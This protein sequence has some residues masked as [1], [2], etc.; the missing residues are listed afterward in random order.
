MASQ[1]RYFDVDPARF[2]GLFGAKSHH[3]MPS[4]AAVEFEYTRTDII[5]EPKA[6]HEQ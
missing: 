1:D 5:R 2:Y 6:Q 3:S 4:A